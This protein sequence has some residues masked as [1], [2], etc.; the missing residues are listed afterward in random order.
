MQRK[1]VHLTRGSLGFLLAKATQHWNETLHRRFTEAGFGHVRPS[2]GSILIPLFE[3]DG[4]RLGEL[5][6][7]GGISK[8]AMTT[9]VRQVEEAG[10][11]RRRPDPEDARASRVYLTD[12]ARRF[13]PVAERVLQELDEQARAVAGAEAVQRISGWLRRFAGI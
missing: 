1:S 9:L 7:R 13:E 8:Q 2:F 6:E 12:A 4:L 10:F 5:A 11:I 3:Q